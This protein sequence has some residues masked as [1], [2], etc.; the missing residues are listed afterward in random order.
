MSSLVIL[1]VPAAVNFPAVVCPNVLSMPHAVL[2]VF[3]GVDV[4]V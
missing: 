4:Y 3:L 1:L 2:V